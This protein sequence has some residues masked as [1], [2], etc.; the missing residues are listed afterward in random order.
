MINPRFAERVAAREVV[1][2]V[3]GLGYVGLPLAIAYATAGFRTVGVDTDERRVEAL[4]RG[5]SHVDDVTGDAVAVAVGATFEPTTDAER[6]AAA[7]VIFLCVPTPFDAT[8]TPDLSYVRAAGETVA[9]HL[10]HGTVVV[11]QSTTY[12]G[13]TTDVLMPTL[14]GGSGLRAGHDFHLAYS[15][16]RVDPGNHTWTLANTPKICG[17]VTRECAEATR[18]VLEAGLAATGLITIVPSPAV[19]ELAKLVENTYRA[20]NIAYV[21]ELAML[22]HEMGIDIWDVLD[23]AAS[24]PF[25]FEPFVPGIGPGGQCIPV[26]PYYLS[27][28]AREYDFHTS[29]IELAGDINLRMV[30]YVMYRIHSFTNRIGRPL[31]GARV[32][33]LGAAFKAGVRDVRNSRAVRVME[34]LEQEGAQVDFSDPLVVELSIGGSRHKAMPLDALSLDDVDLVVVLVRNSAWPVDAILESRVPVFDAVNALGAPCGP[35]HERL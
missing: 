33:C 11:L 34:L 1:V 6:L 26:N 14:E 29:F 20:V 18:I 2:A 12:P 22:A 32:L 24:K 13:T 15:P 10:R 19:A 16:E 5:V 4:R 25:G 17:G 3:V 35:C 9:R 23:A 8:K 21:N 31:D 7:D 27:W 30:S 28:R